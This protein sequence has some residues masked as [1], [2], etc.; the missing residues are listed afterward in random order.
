M[1]GGGKV[2]SEEEERHAKGS[3]HQLYRCAGWA[4]HGDF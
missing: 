2:K 4:L 1:R 3:E